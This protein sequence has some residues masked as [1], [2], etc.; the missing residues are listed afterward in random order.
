MN[1]IKNYV[2]YNKKQSVVK[3][4]A[5]LIA[6]INNNAKYLNISENVLPYVSDD[7]MAQYLQ[8]II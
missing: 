6:N 5:R 1:I 2:S 4:R 7:F 3:Y 8:F